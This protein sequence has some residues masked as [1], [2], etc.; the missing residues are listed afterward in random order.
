MAHLEKSEDKI[1]NRIFVG[2]KEVMNK[3]YRMIER[4]VTCILDKNCVRYVVVENGKQ[5]SR[6]EFANGK[7][8]LCFKNATKALNK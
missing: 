6:R 1:F 7:E 3:D 4:K 2:T 5:I 8:E